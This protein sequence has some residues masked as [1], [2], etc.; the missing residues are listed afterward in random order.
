[1]GWGVG[2]GGGR[3]E[4]KGLEV[5]NSRCGGDSSKVKEDVRRRGRDSVPS[6]VL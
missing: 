2:V 5:D 6:G 3:V 1:M 4:W